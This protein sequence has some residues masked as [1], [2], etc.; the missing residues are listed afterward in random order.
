MRIEF[1]LDI[2]P[3]KSAGKNSKSAF[4]FTGKDGRTKARVVESQR[5]R[6]TKETLMALIAPYAPPS[7][8]TGA[9]SMT[10]ALCYPFPKATPKKV[11]ALGKRPHV[12]RPDLDAMVTTLMDVM[13]TLRFWPD[14]SAVWSI[15]AFKTEGENVGI[16]VTVFDQ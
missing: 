11:L 16:R 9:V 10:V 5:T 14:D 3:P 12:K 7:P 6:G 8:L 1:V 2:V 13:T 15:T 4:T